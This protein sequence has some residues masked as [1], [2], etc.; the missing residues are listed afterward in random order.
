MNLEDQ[1]FLL[2][3]NVLDCNKC[4]IA[5]TTLQKVFG[6]GPFNADIMSISEAPGSE[7]E[8]AARPYQ[9]RAGKLWEEAL[10][11][12]DLSR[13][14][15]YVCNS[16]CCRPINNKLDPDLHQIDNCNA[17]LIKQIDF[18]SPKLILAFGKTAAYA[19]KIITKEQYNKTRMGGMVG[20]IFHYGA[21]G[22]PVLLTYHP[23][24]LLRTPAKCLDVY[25]HLFKAKELYGEL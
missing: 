8:R 11:T 21:A 4:K 23:S 15:V 20:K 16:I 9:G 3:N 7:E 22:V 17:Y 5:Q 19:L 2:K 13:D 1:L 25:Y 18:I 12:I 6:E 10:A 24:Y 14:R